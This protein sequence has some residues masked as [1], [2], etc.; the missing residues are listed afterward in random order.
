MITTDTPVCQHTGPRYHLSMGDVCMGCGRLLYT[1]RS[2]CGIYGRR[3]IATP[4]DH[5]ARARSTAS[6]DRRRTP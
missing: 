4:F 2:A 1:E 5:C 3:P 6:K